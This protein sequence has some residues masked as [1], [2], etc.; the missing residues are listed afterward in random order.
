VTFVVLF[1]LAVVWAVYLV[2]WVRS[3]TEHRRVNSIT[4]FSKHLSILERSQPASRSSMPVAPLRGGAY[5]AP[6]RPK[7]APQK[8]RRR[9]ILFG[10]LA[11]T[12]VTFLG[13]FFVGGM[14]TVLFVLSL[15]LTAAYVTLLASAQKRS[16]ERRSK[17]RYMAEAAPTDRRAVA[18]ADDDEYDVPQRRMYVVG[19]N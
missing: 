10:L 14:L 13:A 15:L 1:I 7:M 6:H 5:F 18:E 9:D 16:L 4:S 19:G 11:A 17:V 2:S 3:R 12:G 8:K